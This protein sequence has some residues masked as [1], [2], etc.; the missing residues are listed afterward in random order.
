MANGRFP[1]E[2][3]EDGRVVSTASVVDDPS[4][5]SAANFAVTHNAASYNDVVG[6]DPRARAAHE[7]TRV[8]HSAGRRRGRVAARGARAAA[9]ADAAHRG[10]P[11]SSRGRSGTAGPHCGVS[12]GA[13]TIWLDR[14]P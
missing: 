10:A 5:P 6:C 1:G 7:A 8:H 12:A 4:L 14:W 13:A 2:A 11:P 3:E 9:R